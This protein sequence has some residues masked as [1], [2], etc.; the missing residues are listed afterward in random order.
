MEYVKPDYNGIY[1]DKKSKHYIKPEI[2]Q[3]LDTAKTGGIISLKKMKSTYPNENEIYT[4]RGRLL[5]SL[6]KDKRRNFQNLTRYFQIGELCSSKPEI[7]QRNGG[8][9][10]NKNEG[11]VLSK[12]FEL[13]H[14]WPP[15]FGDESAAGIMFAPVAIN[16]KFQNHSIESFLGK[17][18]RDGSVVIE[19]QAT[20]WNNDY[21]VE[22]AR[23]SALQQVC[24]TFM[25]KVQYTILECPNVNGNSIAKQLI[26]KPICLEVE[27]T[28]NMFFDNIRTSATYSLLNQN[29]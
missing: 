28:P 29:K 2:N 12:R 14:L 9:L 19:A 3:E 21:L 23:I 16:Q 18:P 25:K 27:G 4:I 15:R 11:I 1:G 5:P 7:D 20:S 22:H 10:D 17:L 8:Y 6:G 24:A 13:A 26:G